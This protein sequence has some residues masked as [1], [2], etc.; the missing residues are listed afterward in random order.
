MR[1]YLSMVGLAALVTASCAPSVN[2][3]QEKTALMQRDRDWSAAAAK[4]D[5]FMTFLASDGSMYPP[6][7]PVVTGSDAIKTMYTQMSGAPGFSLS[8]TANKAAVSGDGMWGYTAGTYKFAA[9]GT[10]EDGKY[11]TIWKKVN[12]AWVVTDDIFNATTPPVYPSEMVQPSSL[13]WMTELPGMP[14]GAKF[15]VVS[16]DPSQ[17]GPFVM[18]LEAPAGYRI[19][20]H[21][22]PTTE[23]VTVLS[24]TVAMSMGDTDDPAARVD[25]PTGGYCVLPAG[26][27]HAFSAK[28]AVTAQVH[29]M[30]PFAITYVNPTDDPRNKK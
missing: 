23:N 20:P 10:K 6:D 30:G 3:E 9:G 25:L 1:R 8:W 22:H 26:A 21:W 16:G 17:S 29:G 11:V 28:T 4:P 7:N 2:V 14:G 12:N 15:T 19:G 18:R 13:K 24:G 5:E 27:H